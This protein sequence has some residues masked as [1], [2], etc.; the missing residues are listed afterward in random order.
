MAFPTRPLCY[1]TNVHPG[2]TVEEVIHGIEQYAAKVATNTNFPIAVG[3]WFSNA[4]I[5]ELHQSPNQLNTIQKSLKENNLSCYTLNAFPYGNFHEKRVKD[6]VYLPDWSD[7][8]RTN[9][10]ISCA[11]NL[12]HLLNDQSEGSISTLPLGFKHH[13]HHADF[14]SQCIKQLIHTASE[15]HNT[16][17]DTGKLI[18]LAIE[19][20]PF[21]MLE[22]TPE[23][24]DF[25]AQLFQTAESENKLDLVQQY[26]GL[27]YDVCHQA[28]EF[29]D[30]T[31]AIEQI[32]AA[33]IRINKVQL[34]CAIEAQNPANNPDISTALLDYLDEKYLHQTMA[35]TPDGNIHKQID[36]TQSLIQQPDDN[37]RTA[38]I[39]R[40]H[41]HVPVYAD[42]I[43]HLHTTR[44][45]LIK[46]LAAIK[47]LDY[48]PDLEVETYTWSV[49]PTDQ[50]N[51]LPDLITGLT[52]ELQATQNLIQNT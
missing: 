33:G 13:D 37:W 16:Y 7:T 40:V 6:K 4:V 5:E 1:C 38:D 21:C 24:L 32:N 49:L 39:W 50:S 20:E 2:N 36:L 19:P 35:R 28:V 30:A 29:E 52:H 14:T 47:K 27:C 34:S 8:Q 9:Y 17:Q 18:R 23:A 11:H 31:S 48:T 43:G 25:F 42:T 22:T 46:A 26:I 51:Q 10:T 41:Y 3:L 45:E 15:L 12:A 44:P